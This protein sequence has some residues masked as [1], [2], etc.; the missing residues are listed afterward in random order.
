[1]EQL[2]EH[3]DYIE[4]VLGDGKNRKELSS[5]SPTPHPSK[6]GSKDKLN[7]GNK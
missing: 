7:M 1:M 6:A 2:N 5:S 4:Q 3:K